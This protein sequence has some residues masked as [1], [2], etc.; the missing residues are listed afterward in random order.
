[1]SNYEKQLGL[2]ERLKTMLK[3]QELIPRVSSSRG[4]SAE[5]AELILICAGTHPPRTVTTH[6]AE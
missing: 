2:K 1:M 5:T 6:D 3:S 4:A